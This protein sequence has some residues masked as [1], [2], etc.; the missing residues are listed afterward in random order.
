VQRITVKFDPAKEGAIS[1]QLLINTDLDGGASVIL[2]VVA[3]AG[4]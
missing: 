4:K 1:R 2:P 3:E